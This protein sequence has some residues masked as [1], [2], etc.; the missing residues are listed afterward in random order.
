[1]TIKGIDIS[2]YQDGEPIDFEKIK[3]AGIDFVIVK[4]TEGVAYLNPH[5]D[6]D[7]YDAHQAGLAVGA[8]TFFHPEQDGV[9]QA[10]K[11]H[12]AMEKHPVIAFAVIDFEVKPETQD[13]AHAHERLDECRTVLRQH[14]HR[15]VTYSYGS[16]LAGIVPESCKFCPTDPLWDAAYQPEEPHAPKPW[17]EVTI[18][19]NSQT[20]HVP[21]IAGAVDLDVFE[22]DRQAFERF[23]E[24][25][26][27]KPA[28]PN[29][30]PDWY[31]RLLEYPPSKLRDAGKVEK[32]AG[33]EYQTGDDVDTIQRKLS[34]KPSGR[35][36]PA[37]AN[38]VKGFQ[39]T[40]GLNV[41]G[42][43]GPTTAR[44]LEEKS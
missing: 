31:H 8:Y 44:K 5:F 3:E 43:V 36:D 34:M 10:N 19:Q 39:K 42:I 25:G 29:Q 9:A 41:D 30:K 17:T 20:G 1:M 26:N 7:V 18:W 14:G 32:H 37:T 6:R 28:A 2:A 23:L 15:T 11:F 12:Q 13:A 4:A 35:Y 33:H 38:H 21:G 16:F 24:S 27:H 22:G 40:H